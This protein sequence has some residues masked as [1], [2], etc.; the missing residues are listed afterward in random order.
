L[1]LGALGTQT[2]H[3]QRLGLPKVI[4]RFD[5]NYNMLMGEDADSLQTTIKGL[6]SVKFNMGFQYRLY[7]GE[8]GMYFSPGLMLA[9]NEFR[10]KDNISLYNQAQIKGQNLSDS[11][12]I[13]TDNADNH[14]YGKSKLQLMY[15]RLPLELGFATQ[16]LNFAAGGFVDVLLNAKHKRKYRDTDANDTRVREVLR[17]NENFLTNIIQYGVTARVEYN[18]IGLFAHYNLSEL[19]QSG[20]G[21]KVNMFQV[22]LSFTQGSARKKAKSN[23]FE[24]PEEAPEERP[25]RGS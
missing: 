21:P 14:Q 18:G 12:R 17:G 9:L 22:G 25:E 6:G 13:L 15:A 23:L 8:T 11:L 19:F 16:K 7:F 5:L 4:N 10:F 3:A 20:K 2:S 1:A 24:V